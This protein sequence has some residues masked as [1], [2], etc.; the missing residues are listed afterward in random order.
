M[1]DFLQAR[2][3]LEQSFRWYAADIQKHIG[4]APQ[5]EERGLH[6]KRPPAVR[7]KYFQLREIHRHVI[8]VNGI[9]ILVTSAVKN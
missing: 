2:K 4:M 6:P 8:D 1:A 3:V 7:Q 5:Q 9:S